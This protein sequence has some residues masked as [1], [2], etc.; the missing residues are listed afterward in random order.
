MRSSIAF[1]KAVASI[2]ALA[3][4]LSAPGWSQDQG[5][6]GGLVTDPTG[7]VVANAKVIVANRQR[8]FTRETTS[9]AE[10][11]YSVAK[12][13]IGDYEITAEAAGFQKLLRTGIKLMVGQTIRVDL[14]LS[15]GEVTQEV[16]V[17]G[18]VDIVTQSGAVSSVIT[19]SQVMNLN[20]NGRNWMSLTTLVPGVAP[21][22]ENN[23][24]PVRAGFGSSQLIVS[25]SGSR[26]NDSNVEVDGGNINNE[27][28][29]GRNNVIFPVVDS[30][31]EF[32][33]ATS[34]YGADV[35]KRPG[36]AIQIATK[37]GTT[38]FHGTAYEFVRNDKMDANNFFLNRQINPIGGKPF[39]QP[40]KWNI[41]G[42]NLGGP[43]T[44]PGIYNTDRTKTFF[45]WSQSW[46]RFR[47]GTVLSGN[48]PSQRMRQGDFSE[49]DT[50]SPNYNAVVASGCR[51]PIDPDTKLPFPGN[52][53]PIDPNA[54]AMLNGLIP[55]PNNGPVGYISAPSLPN[56]WRQENIRIDQNIGN[57]TRLF[58]RYTQ[59]KH[60][61]N[62]T[63][64]NYDAAVSRTDF[65]TKAAVV[66]F[67]HGFSPNLLNE[68]V[69]SF[70][71][72][73]INFDA[74]ATS[75]SP[76]G[77]I[78]KPSNWTATTIF[79]AN[80]TNA[81]AQVLPVLNVS[82][83]VPFSANPNTSLD[84][85][86]SRHA[87]LNLKDNII[88]HV[89]RHTL[90]FGVFFLDWHSYG[91]N[92]GNAPQGTYT[93]NGTGALTTGNGLADM[94]LGRITQYSEATGVVGG[95]PEGGWGTYRGRMKDFETYFQDDWN[96]S[97]RLTLNLGLRYARRGPWHEGSNPTRDSG[98]IPEQYDASRE[99]QLN[100]RSFFI[101]GT[102]HNYTTHGNGLVPCG[103]NGIP[104]GCLTTY[105]K[106]VQPRFGFAYDMGGAHKMVIRGG[107]GIFTDTGFSR[108]PGAVLA[109]GPPPYGQAPTVFDI[110]GYTT[111][112][113][114]LLGPTGFRAF[115]M[116]GIRPKIHQFNLTI[117]R[118]L[119]G[120]N[121]VSV[122]YVGSRSRDLD[123]DSDINQ[124]PLNAGT[125]N[126]PALAGTTGCDA[127]GN[128]DV[129]DIMI[130]AR[131]SSAFFVPFR[132]YTVMQWVTN[133]ASASYNSLQVNYRK[134]MGHGLSFQA[135]YTWSHAIDDSSDGAFL[136]GVDDWND[137]SRWRGNSEFDR[138]HILQINYVYELPFFKGSGNKFL[139][140]GLGGW[141]LSG[142]TSFFSGIPIN[143]VCNHS[144]NRNGIG[145]SMKCNTVG[146]FGISKSVEAHPVF[147]PTLRWF[148]P[149]TI[150]MANL[151]QFRADNAP[152]MF[153]T[154]GRN[155][156]HG[157][158]R[159]NWDIALMKNFSLFEGS[160]LQF[161]LETYNTF[162][163]TQYQ[164][165]QAGCGGTTPYGAPCTGAQ[166]VGNGMVTSAWAPRQVQLGLKFMF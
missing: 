95:V 6:I 41:F 105:N 30:I 137:L 106:S 18:N 110:Q 79:A 89:S 126:V 115:P 160:T 63:N 151:S 81:Q 109:Y 114:G 33:I 21:M 39:K 40:L 4:F 34:T 135:A 50:A 27:P 61:Y 77:S 97:R 150:A 111:P 67:S 144:G 43:V 55:L 20:L 15:V 46:T 83:G 14:Q 91:Y 84:K 127:A 11:E 17:T 123:R 3:L 66:N 58:G 153:G 139:K 104:V 52:Q 120:N 136:T 143:F 152:G 108:S 68:F 29:G 93:F 71:S 44:I 166:N 94:Y 122:A 85:V 64:G 102:G 157:P 65:P 124:I 76:A 13:P 132:G 35:G 42:Y 2:A 146:D 24:N 37:S 154:M 125:K 31:A 5:M 38:S 87:S 54:A 49:C 101:P 47:E 98:F 88:Y 74:I 116:E 86:K 134:R 28:G 59:E 128:C 141:Q 60:N 9:N 155:T 51:L 138:R 99:A 48:V 112:R 145:K 165:I 10:G 78:R 23:F 162:N 121:I 56:D 163:H 131:R 129:Q 148:D 161:R 147:G 119:P 156:L 7:A 113:T 82:G 158:G 107:Y 103:E 149:S 73:H 142:I 32:N 90:K 70:A 75:S 72:V 1:G 118:E 96:V 92:G 22:N 62:Y 80:A 100:I 133:S 25:F 8:G 26:V 45:F 12:V 159:N 53:V 57:N 140:N 19:E 36:A 164:G 117:E 69:A 16:T 130:N